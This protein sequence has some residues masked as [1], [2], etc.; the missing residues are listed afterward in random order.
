MLEELSALNTGQ[1]PNGDYPFIL[2][3]GER[4][5]YNANQIYRDPQWR[6]VDPLG[7]LRIHPEDAA[8]LGLESGDS[9]TCKNEIGSVESVVELDEGM[10][11]GVTS[12]PHGYGMRYKGSQP[13]GPQINRLTAAAHCEPLS[14]TPYHKYVRVEIEKAV[15]SVEKW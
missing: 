8:E 12:L 2:M 11:R 3:A 9:V 4:R 14:K 1:M 5:S 15:S 10:L 13:I 6:K 7:A